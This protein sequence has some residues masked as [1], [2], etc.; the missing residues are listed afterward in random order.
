MAKHLLKAKLREEKGKNQ[1]RR[2]RKAGS[3][4]GIV[5]GRSGETI[6]VSFSMRDLEKIIYSPA[7]FNAIFDMEIDGE[8]THKKPMVLMKEYQLEP[9]THQFL[10]VSFYR[11][12]EDRLIQ[13]AVPIN[14]IGTSVGVKDQGG[15]LDV[16]RREVDVECFPGDI[17]ESIDFDISAFEINDT[18]RV[19]DLVVD[20]KV[21]IIGEVDDVV[22]QVLPPKRVEE[23]AEEGE[24][25]EGEGEAEEATEE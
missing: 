12:H 10:H 9:V 16:V 13:V 23:V 4:P 1:M 19:S 25:G 14:V 15:R 5:F 2:L 24:E 8:E 21:K 22:L 18:C 20:E 11:V 17:P 7:G 6:P 3:T